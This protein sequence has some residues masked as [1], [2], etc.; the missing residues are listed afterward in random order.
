MKIRVGFGM[1]VGAATGAGRE[2]FWTVVDSCESLGFDSIWFSERVTGSIP[3]PLAAMAAVAGRTKRL[4]FG[5]SVMILPGR[6]PVFLAKELAT[7][8]VL[9]E[10]RLILAFGLGSEAPGEHGALMVERSEAAG[11]TAEAVTLMKKLWTEESVAF[12]GNYFSIDGVSIGLKPVQEPHPDVWFGGRSKAAARRVGR[13]GEGWLPSFVTV[14]E[15]PALAGVV[16]SFAAEA[17]REIDEEHFGALVA[18]VPDGRDP[19]ALRSAVAARRPG[20]D[21]A[22]VL[23]LGGLKELR[24]RVEAFMDKGASKFVVVPATAPP[25]WKE[26]LGRIHQVIVEP[27]EN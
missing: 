24:A 2:A 22:D 17:G 11:R 20:A 12:H 13:Y 23:V 6:N 25:D 5:P 10:G 7:I 26:E 1:G 18:Y 19:E 27:L 21:P 8:D 9:S 15:Y 4:K 14:D 16:R 3:D